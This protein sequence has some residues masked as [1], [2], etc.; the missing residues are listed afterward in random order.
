MHANATA[1]ATPW[2]AIGASGP[3]PENSAS[4]VRA[5]AGSPT[6][7]RPRLASVIPSWVPEIERSRPRMARRASLAFAS[8]LRIIASMRVRR[9]DTSAN[10]AATKKAFASTSSA[11]MPS[12]A[13]TDCQDRSVMPRWANNT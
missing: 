7:P 3:S 1:P 4:I 2:V 6:Q 12:R 11:T 5:I 10:S 13:R 8:P 9:E